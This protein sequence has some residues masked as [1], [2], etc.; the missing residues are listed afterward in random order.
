VTAQ[1]VGPDWVIVQSGTQML[2]LKLP[3]RAVREPQ[4][5]RVA[6]GTAKPQSAKQRS[7]ATIHERD[8]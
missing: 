2:P 4:T 7:I 6:Q 3:Q 5:T 1:A 8:P